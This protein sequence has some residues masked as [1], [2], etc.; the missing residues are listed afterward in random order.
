MSKDE[1]RCCNCGKLLFRGSIR[2]GKVEVKCPNCKTVNTFEINSDGHSNSWQD[3]MY[4]NRK[5]AE[6]DLNRRKQE[7]KGLPEQI[8]NPAQIVPMEQSVKKP[9]FVKKR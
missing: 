5:H 3:R 2:D 6:S 4:L 8:K 7:A 9:A 1:K